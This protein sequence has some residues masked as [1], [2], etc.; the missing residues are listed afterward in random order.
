MTR[1]VARTQP[2]ERFRRSARRIAPALAALTLAAGVAGAM[3]EGW[4]AL[5]ARR[6]NADVRALAAGADRHVR[7]GA[8]PEALLARALFL[9]RR[10]RIEDAEALGPALLAHR[11]RRPD[12]A[13]SYLHSVGAARLRRAFDRIDAGE[14]DMAIPEVNLAKSA[15][16]AAL[17]VDP[18]Y[19]DAKVNLEIAMRLVRDFPRDGEDGLDDPQARPRNVWTELPGMPRGAP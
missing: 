15:Y 4:A 12:M 11:S 10:D 3:V 16:R 13:A 7:A 14:M 9:L 5:S 18:G 8:A 6:T 19:W 2:V 17:G 1:P